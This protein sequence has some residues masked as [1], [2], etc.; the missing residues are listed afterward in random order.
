MH[1]GLV[2][3]LNLNA[4]QMCINKHSNAEYKCI[5]R[6]SF[7]SP[8]MKGHVGLRGSAGFEFTV[9]PNFAKFSFAK[10]IEF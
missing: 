3:T 2:C 10:L 9:T 5:G 8:H 4:H 6:G 7:T 1:Y